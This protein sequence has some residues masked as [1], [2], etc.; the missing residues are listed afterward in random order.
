MDH[1]ATVGDRGV[2]ELILF[3]SATVSVTLLVVQSINNN[4]GR[5]VLAFF[6]SIAIGLSQV[7]LYKLMAN[8]SASEVVAFVAGGPAGNLIAQWIKRHDV[9]KIKELHKRNAEWLSRH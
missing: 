7:Y 6:T 8:A 4:H 1:Q 5:A 3:V 2:N 9:A